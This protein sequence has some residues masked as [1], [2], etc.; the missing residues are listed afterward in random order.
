MSEA[1]ASFGIDGPIAKK[2]KQTGLHER[3]IAAHEEFKFRP[4][5]PQARI[6][7]PQGPSAGH[8]VSEHGNVKARKLRSWADNG[9]EATYEA[10]QAELS[11][12]QGFVPQHQS[13]LVHTHPSA[14]APRQ[15]EPGYF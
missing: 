15:D 4:T 6:N 10:E 11:P 12:D 3:Q 9:H 8:L 13:R 14:G 7:P 5:T 1:N 2:T